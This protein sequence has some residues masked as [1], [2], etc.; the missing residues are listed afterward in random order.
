MSNDEEE[1]RVIEDVD[2]DLMDDDA[3][4]NREKWGD[5]VNED[6]FDTLDAS[7]AD[8]AITPLRLFVVL[9]LE[10][11]DFFGAMLLLALLAFLTFRFLLASL[12]SEAFI[13]TDS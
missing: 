9:S 11:I 5:V 1:D 10:R 3:G 6:A 13:C 12:L 4:I 8:F 7:I 2:I